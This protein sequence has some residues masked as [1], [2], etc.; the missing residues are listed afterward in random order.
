M[1]LTDELIKRKMTAAL[2]EPTVPQ[3]V[4]ERAVDRINAVTAGRA[5]EN[6]LAGLAA[7]A[8]AQRK[9]ELA[10]AAVTGRLLSGRRPQKN[11]TSAMMTEQLVSNK[12]FC[13]LTSG[14]PV[15]LAHDIRSGELI[16]KLAQPEMKKSA[17]VPLEIKQEKLPEMPVP[18]DLSL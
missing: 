17:E 1:E 13:A 7:S 12:R 18:D 14:D 9:T 6:E 3:E 11:V 15:R 5:A 4:V 16:K 8:P 10:A 2:N